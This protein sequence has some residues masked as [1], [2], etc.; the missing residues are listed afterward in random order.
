[1]LP[2]LSKLCFYQYP[3]RHQA[4]ERSQINR[5]E[6]IRATAAAKVF[7]VTRPGILGI[8]SLKILDE[9]IPPNTFHAIPRRKGIKIIPMD[10]L[11][12]ICNLSKG[13]IVVSA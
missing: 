10:E 12:I 3:D 4:L 5:S 13:N 7:L 1:M 11:P 6:H 2:G 9:N 8:L